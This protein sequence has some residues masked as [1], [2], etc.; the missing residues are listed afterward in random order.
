MRP[1]MFDWRGNE[2]VVGSIVVYPGRQSS[3]MWM[4]E[5]EVLAIVEVDHW[6]ITQIGLRVQPLRQGTFSR[7]NMKPKTLTALER[8]T[9]I[10]QCI[11]DTVI[12][13]QAIAEEILNA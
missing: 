11:E 5:A 3:S 1:R 13:D 2:I 12:T 6:G 10:P 9:V 7:T 8:V 4:I